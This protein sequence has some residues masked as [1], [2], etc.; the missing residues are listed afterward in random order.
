MR[1]WLVCLGV[2]AIVS[3]VGCGDNA[4]VTPVAEADGIEAG[5]DAVLGEDAAADA[6]DATATVD[7]ADAAVADAADAISPTDAGA[8]ATAATD[9][10]LEDIAAGSDALP[11]DGAAGTDAAAGSDGDAADGG[12]DSA[13]CAGAADCDDNN[14]CT[15]DTCAA[16]ACSHAAIANCVLP[17]SACDASHPCASGKCD[18]ASHVCVA[19][20]ASADCGAGFL[21][22]ANVCF[23]APG[24]K[25]DVDCKATKQVCSVSDGVCVDCNTTTDCGT[26]QICSAHLCIAA[27][28]CKSSKDCIAVCD[29]ATGTCVDCLS[30]TDCKS[31]QF[32]NLSTHVCTADV[33]TGPG[34]AGN[35]TFA[36]LPNGSGFGPAI[37]CEDSNACTDDSCKLLS[38]CIH[39]NNTAVCSD[40]SACTTA[41]ACSAG[42]CVGLT[43]DCNDKNVC[44]AD[45]C[46]PATGCTHTNIT[47]T[48]DDGLACTGNDGCVAGTC[49][50]TPVSCDDGKQCTADV[51]VEGAGCAHTDLSGTPC[52]DGN[53]CTADD[54]CSAGSCV[55]GA[56]PSCDDKNPCTID[57]CAIASGCVHIDAIGSPCDDASLCTVS[58]A[59]S[60]GKCTGTAIVCDDLNPCTDNTCAPADGCLF[61]QNTAPCSDK[62]ACTGPDVC[63]A[64]KCVSGATV[65]CNDNNVCTT[66]A[67][68][69]AKGCVYTGTTGGACDDGNFCTVSDVCTA[70]V[71]GGA[72]N[73]CDDGNACTLD[74]CGS[75]ACAH[76]NTVDG[77]SCGTF[78]GCTGDFCTAGTCLK[79]SDRLWEKAID[80]PSAADTFAGAAR[81][82][83][84]GFILAGET[85]VAGNSQNGWLVKLDG[86]GT[87]KWVKSY[88]GTSEDRL[89]G[90]VANADGS[91]TGVGAHGGNGGDGWLL[92]VDSAGTSK[93]D[94]VFGTGNSDQFRGIAAA[95]GGGWIVVGNKSVAQFPNFYTDDGWLM[96][97]AADGS[98]TWEKTYGS[99]QAGDVLYAVVG[100]ADG[101][102]VAAGSRGL[103]A[104]FGAGWLLKVDA[105]GAQ[106]WSR[107]YNQNF[108]VD[109]RGLAVD[110][111]GFAIVGSTTGANG[112]DALLQF[113]GADGNGTDQRTYNKSTQD[114]LFGI[115]SIPTGGFL[116]AGQ[117]S[118]GNGTGWFMRSDSL[119]N[120][121]WS[122]TWGGN[123]NDAALAVEV[124]ADFTAIVAGVYSS[125][126]NVGDGFVRHIDLFG[127]A[128]CAASG[129]CISKQPNDCDDK[130]P[131]TLDLC[132][133]GV[134]SHSNL[135]NGTICSAA[136]DQ[137]DNGACVPN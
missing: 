137:C 43:L 34:C 84:G 8:D 36:C 108:G 118:G 111:A 63:A 48:C 95:P 11:G 106:V 55:G 127:N 98:T 13:Q 119:G 92:Q 130:N 133:A 93:I 76:S 40:G 122:K 15:T 123:N 136:G 112:A 125:G 25:S 46:D 110:G 85:G 39:V 99:G 102:F 90:V 3:L 16:G 117:Q 115:S 100:L 59:C 82:S 126:N 79:A 67:C 94:A 58:D 65:V 22:Q 128:G 29:T 116:L 51:C 49:A 53:A 28:P 42:T 105:N 24:C 71:C 81:T 60:A 56:A 23:A 1:N 47:S 80:G 91:I 73:T 54:L 7:A 61:T 121:Q 131:C 35:T 87:Q 12:A 101:S 57:S 89:R 74:S 10:T 31:A 83:D 33:C 50:G 6:Q 32:C 120:E 4:T 52:T 66:D 77:T 86:G 68:E 72:P 44:T 113:A 2:L 18:P 41:D 5:T 88:G 75:N 62:D 26:N 27:P 69:P 17:P 124:E 129:T 109:F 20:L 45:T 37:A 70:G 30:D 64:G 134:C 103:N 97:F 104:G 114:V 21:C 132:S 9:A 135:A 78:D 96:R 107:T 19:C 38:G 14:P